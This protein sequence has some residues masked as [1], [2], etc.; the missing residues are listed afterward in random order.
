MIRISGAGVLCYSHL[1]SGGLAILLGKEKETP[2]WRQGSN[3]WSSFSG[4]VDSTEEACYGAAREFVEESLAVIPLVEGGNVPVTIDEITTLLSKDRDMS[5]GG[6]VLEVRRKAEEV[7]YRYF[8]YIRHIPY[9]DYSTIFKE[10][11]KQLLDLDGIFRAF[12]V[13]RK[14]TAG[15]C[16]PRCVFPGTRL[17]PVLVVVNFKLLSYGSTLQI[18]I[19]D[20]TSGQN[21]IIDVEISDSGR[22]EAETF[23]AARDAVLSRLSNIN[24]PILSH[25]AVVV[26]R[27]HGHV[28]GAFVKKSYLEKSEVRWWSLNDLEHTA[29]N[30]RTS[31]RQASDSFR[32]YF[33]ESV[34]LLATAVRRR[35]ME[36][37]MMAT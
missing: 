26:N 6:G 30:S 31:G 23:A 35:A 5:E 10:T 8:V 37:E 18:T 16:L 21:D 32:Y 24:D 36:F 22:K 2:G 19:H 4:K 25:P 3:K 33:L 7:E 11:R 14:G 27:L 17:S 1:P 12:Q 28:M 29:A 20:E 15:G 9:K 34:P 13:C